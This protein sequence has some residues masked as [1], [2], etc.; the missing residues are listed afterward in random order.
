MSAPHGPDPS[1]SG[2]DLTKP[3]QP[4]PSQGPPPGQAAPS[5]PYAGGANSSAQGQYPPPPYGAPPAPQ[6]QPGWHPQQ[7]QP[8]G[9]PPPSGPQL[10]GPYSSLVGRP[11]TSDEK[12]WGLLAHLGGL[13][14]GFLAPLLVLL[15]K[16]GE[17]PYSRAQAVESLNFQIT[18][19]IAYFV[20]SVA[21]I[22]LIGFLMLPIVA[23]A[24]LV[25]VILATVAA[26]NGVVYRY[27]LTLR[28]IS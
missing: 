28:L 16:G 8:G 22:L 6:T 9:H 18:L 19:A 2:P 11:L 3:P 17:S 20:S 23:V 27:P 25:L 5:N 24:H 12:T 7:G 13:F 4:A 1:P 21:I 10:T 15:V 26:N 14:I